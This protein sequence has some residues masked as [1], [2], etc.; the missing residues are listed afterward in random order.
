MIEQVE[1]YSHGVLI[2]G[3]I[4]IPQNANSTLRLPA[5]VMSHGMANNRDEAEQ[6]SYL[7]GRLEE[8]GYVVLRFDFRGCGVSGGQRG[9]MFIGTEWPQDLQAAVT[10]LETRPEV[11]P[12][13]IAAVGSSWGG[14]VTIFTAAV[15]RRI[16]CA[17]SLAAPAN[18]RRWLQT[19]WTTWH[20]QAGWEQFLAEVAANRRQL[21]AGNPSKT[22]RLIGGFIPV[23]ESQ[24]PGLEQFLA[25]HPYIIADIS[26]EIAD[27]I[28]QFTPEDFVSRVAPTPLLIIQGTADPLVDTQEA[29]AYYQRAGEGKEL[30]LV[31]GGIHQLLSG[32]TAG[33]V[34]NR[35]LLWLKEHLSSKN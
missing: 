17:I 35:I 32:D 7:A 6:H 5:V 18:G 3:S 8:E 1:F 34:S 20:G 30:Y 9:Q 24:L 10:Y 14:G 22:V 4:H 26:L 16:H 25:D 28:F 13:R 15:D 2:C 11:D 19:Q 27:D 21:V 12:G 31:E 33:P 29:L 23:A